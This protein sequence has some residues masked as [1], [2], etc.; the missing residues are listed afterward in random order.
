MW[1]FNFI[2]LPNGGMQIFM[3]FK[4]SKIIRNNFFFK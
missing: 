4:F 1:S 2:Y 3:E